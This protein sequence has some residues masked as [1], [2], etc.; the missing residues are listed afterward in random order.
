MKRALVIFGVTL[1]LIASTALW[2][3]NANGLL[4][5]FDMVTLGILIVLV[6]FAVI[7]GIRRLTSARRGEPGEDELSR[8]ILRRAAALSYYISL[9]LWIAILIIKDRVTMDQ[10]EMLGAGILGMAMV[11]VVCWIVFQL[12]G[13]RNA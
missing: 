3:A 6:A 7:I 11:W 1:L 9:Y 2:L 8:N 12:R 13:V 5:Q 10:E 4:S